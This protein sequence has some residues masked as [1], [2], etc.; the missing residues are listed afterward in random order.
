VTDVTGVTRRAEDA[1]QHDAGTLQWN[2]SLPGMTRRAE[3]APSCQG[4]MELYTVNRNVSVRC[5]QAT[6]KM[7]SVS[8][9]QEDG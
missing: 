8:D 2:T 7:G 6:G 5:S 4:G 9:Q 1:I 3:D